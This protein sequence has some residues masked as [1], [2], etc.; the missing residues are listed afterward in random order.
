M[1]ASGRM[2][3]DALASIAVARLSFSQAN[4]TYM[5]L[6]DVIKSYKKEG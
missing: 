4:R 1:M 3:S 6:L 5:A 2:S